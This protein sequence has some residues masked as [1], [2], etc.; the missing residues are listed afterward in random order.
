MV[1]LRLTKGEADAGTAA[2]NL[3]PKRKVKFWIGQ[4][5]TSRRPGE[6]NPYPLT[7]RCPAPSCSTSSTI[8]LAVFFFQV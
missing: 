8:D 1:L 6:G 7:R 5:S 2:T 3:K 4:R